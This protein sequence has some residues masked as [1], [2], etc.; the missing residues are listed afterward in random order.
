MRFEQALRLS[1]HLGHADVAHGR[2]LSAEILR[3]AHHAGLRGATTLQGIAGFG[4]SGRIHTT[5]TWGL[6]DR[7]P[8]TVYVLDAPERIRAFVTQ[9]DDVR[10]QCRIVC[11]EVTLAI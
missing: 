3:R 11:D 8:I 2:A 7:T 5:P 1:I 10:A 9:L 6:V 4:L